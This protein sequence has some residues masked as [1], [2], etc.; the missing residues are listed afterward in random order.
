MRRTAVVLARDQM[1]R[2]RLSTSFDN[3]DWWVAE[4]CS[5]RKTASIL[6]TFDIDLIL[7]DLDQLDPQ[8]VRI[9][10]RDFRI[11][12]S[13]THA[14][15]IAVLVSEETST[16]IEGNLRRL[17]DGVLRKPLA[18]LAVRDWLY[19]NFPDG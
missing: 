19:T 11:G 6:A 17:I 2:V 1:T 8:E 13:S 5:P 18:P 12:Q 15:R 16:A 7:I 4:T 14:K 10:C 9:L 3:R